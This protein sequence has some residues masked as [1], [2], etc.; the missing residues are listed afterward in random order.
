MD[1]REPRHR[2][3]QRVPVDF[4]VNKMINGVPHLTRTKN[5][6][7]QGLYLHRLL[8]PQ[9]PPKARISL[10]FLLP[11]SEEIIWTEVEVMHGR[12]TRRGVGLRFVDLAPRHAELID[13]F[14]E[15][16]ALAS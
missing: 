6:S 5:L 12:N 8:E 3:D 11:G 10:E 16:R 7:R 14:I 15:S 1:A 2:L 13:Q 4:Y 9:T